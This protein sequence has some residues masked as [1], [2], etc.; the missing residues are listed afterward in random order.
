MD[1]WNFLAMAAAN[2]GSFKKRKNL[3]FAAKLQAMQHNEEGEKSSMAADD[4][5]ILRSTLS[6]DKE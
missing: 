5:G 2:T 4:F 6:N 1:C 3:D